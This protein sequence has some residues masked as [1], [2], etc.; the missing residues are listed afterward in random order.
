MD[1]SV[2]RF[3]IN[4]QIPIILD[5]KW[6]PICETWNH[7]IFTFINI[8]AETLY[9]VLNTPEDSDIGYTTKVDF[10]CPN[11]I[12][13]KLKEF[14]PAPENIKPNIE[15]LSDYQKEIGLKTGSI[16]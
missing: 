6:A 2:L 5:D 13:D 7:N 14:V 8:D 15:W 16:R 1:F 11:E 10:S 4:I 12:H 9:K 3:S